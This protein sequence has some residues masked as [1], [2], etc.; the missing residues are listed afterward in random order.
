MIIISL[1]SI[2]VPLLYS[3]TPVNIRTDLRVLYFV[4]PM[5]G[6]APLLTTAK[7]LDSIHLFYTAF[8]VVM[9]ILETLLP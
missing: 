8:M 9:V 7:P 3:I 5:L 6:G 1:S 2:M 4:L